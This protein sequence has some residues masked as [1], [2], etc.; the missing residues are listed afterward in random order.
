MPD[1]MARAGAKLVEV[2]TTNRT[3]PQDY[4]AAIGPATGLVLKVLGRI[5]ERGDLAEVP[6]PDRSDPDVPREQLAVLTV[7]YMDGLRVDRL[8][9][10]LLEGE[11]AR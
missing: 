8:S 9:L 1:I 6:V 3:H 10:R 4:A 2:G 5:P 7:E 11:A